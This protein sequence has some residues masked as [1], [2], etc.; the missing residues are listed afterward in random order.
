M[1][2]FL[3]L[4]DSGRFTDQWDIENVVFGSSQLDEVGMNSFLTFQ[5][6]CHSW[7]FGSSFSGVDLHVRVHRAFLLVPLPADPA[8]VGFLPGVRQHV[9]FQVDFL[10]KAFAAEL[11]A[12]RFLLLVESL[13]CLQ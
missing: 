3:R 12:E 1:N 11:A 2:Y 6:W 4:C 7:I 10:D 8:A 13:V 5:V 9:S